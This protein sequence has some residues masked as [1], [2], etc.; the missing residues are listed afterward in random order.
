MPT[1][2]MTRSLIEKLQEQGLSKTIPQTMTEINRIMN[3]T[4]MKYV[5]TASLIEGALPALKKLKDAGVKIGILTR[6]CREYTDEVLKA[7]GLFRFADEVAARD[8]CT[9][10]KPD[11]TQ[12]YWLIG[13]MKVNLSEVVM[14]GDHPVDALCARNA[15]IRFVGVLTGSWKAEQTKQLGSTVIPSVKELPNLLGI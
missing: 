8:D 1:Y 6:G 9:S 13:K 12:V 2:E 11:P 15:G 14:V 3:E 5:S 4:E 10:P 7:T